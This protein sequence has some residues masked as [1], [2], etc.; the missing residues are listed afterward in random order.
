MAEEQSRRSSR[1]RRREVREESLRAMAQSCFP[2]GRRNRA[3]RVNNE[4]AWC[5]LDKL[6]RSETTALGHDHT[7]SRDSL[8]VRE[9]Q[10]SA[11]DQ[12]GNPFDTSLADRLCSEPPGLSIDISCSDV[13]TGDAVEGEMPR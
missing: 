12:E 5:A 1:S 3:A 13:T 10:T 8:H 9:V 2:S 11:V 4:L 7:S 6:A